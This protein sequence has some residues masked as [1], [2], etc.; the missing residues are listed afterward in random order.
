LPRLTLKPAS[1][2]FLR[3]AALSLVG[4]TV[5][6]A[7]GAAISYAADEARP[8]VATFNLKEGQS[9]VPLDQTLV[10]R[11]SRPVTLAA[12]E[13]AL[14]IEPTAGGRVSSDAS[15]RMFTWTPDGNLA[16]LTRYTVTL[17]AFEDAGGH[18]FKR[19]AWHFTTT[20]LPR[21]LSLTPAGG[22]ALADGGELEIGTRATLA[23]N[24]AMN[25]ARTTLHGNGGPLALTWA[26]DGKSATFATSGLA[27]GPLALSLDPASADS[28]GRPAAAWQLKAMVV[29]R[30]HI[31]TIPLRFPALVQIPNDGYGARDQAGYQ[32]ANMVFEYLTE[33][34][35]TR[36]TALYTNV[37]DAIGPVR[38]GRFISFDLVRH[39][40]GM[41]FLS[42]LSDPSYAR[43]HADP[44]PAFFDTTGY[45]Y[46]QPGRVAPN[47]LFIS[48]DAVQRAENG[49]GVADFALPAATAPAL[50]GGQ[51]ATSVTVSE[52]NSTYA[53]DPA[54]GT[55]GKVEDRHTMADASLGQPLR[56]F[57]LIVFHTREW[58]TSFVEDVGGGHARDFDMDAGGTA[59][60]Y[61]LGQEYSA[62]WSAPDRSSPYV[63]TLASG[64]TV[65]LP[66][67]L[68][69]VDVVS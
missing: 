53:Y 49:S 48:G 14:T 64:Q 1:V 66:N 38:S 15:R 35:I 34:G 24:D 47:N 25:S 16:D 9:E 67:G 2:L 69:W 41:L 20:I 45:Y 26:K 3:W 8:T 51:P 27:I 21:V 40:K 68:T 52:H 5:L 18:A 6:F 29:Y 37:P 10:F 54:T 31:H 62:H 17:A 19:S 42:G 58:V 30:I 65:T 23:F 22:Q 57:M 55:Y 56:V 63:F 11:L 44:V 61:Y 46:R 33:G 4:L 13:K 39:Y 50:S 28:E 12:I 60:I 32:A 7:A 43:L 59:E 36:T